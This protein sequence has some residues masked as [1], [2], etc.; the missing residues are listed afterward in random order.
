MPKGAAL[1]VPYVLRWQ[2]YIYGTGDK[3]V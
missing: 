2:R 1:A 3:P